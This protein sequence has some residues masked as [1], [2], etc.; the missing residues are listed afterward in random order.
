MLRESGNYVSG[1]QLCDTF[2]VSRT[3]VWKVINQLKEEGYQV[4]AVRNR[5]YRIADSPDVCTE[6]ELNSLMQNRTTWAGQ[7]IHYYQEID[8][9]NIRAKQM[10]EQGAPQGTLV[11]ADMQT[12]GRGRR[13]RGWVSPPGS[14]IYMSLLL[15]P[16][17]APDKAPM[18]TL[19]MAYSVAQALNHCLKND[20]PQNAPEVRIKWPNDIVLN[21]KKIVGILTEMST[22]I[23]YINHVVI[24]VGIN[25]NMDSFPEEIAASATSLRIETGK[26][27]KRAPFIV[28]I[29]RQFEDNYEQFVRCEDLTFLQKEYDCL[30]VNC[31]REVV[32]HEPQHTYH[33]VALGINE[34]GELIVRCD[35]G[36]VETVY[37]GEVSVRGIYGYV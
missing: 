17:F 36:T 31:G 2:G 28:E 8:S 15:K 20:F 32:I 18:L 12:A 9:T 16:T 34:K 24:G 5:G 7:Y 35:D 26:M 25:V 33:A 23:D 13:G 6:E 4:D 14:S 1:Q 22:E 21:G 3:A 11:V 37:A 10:G 30:L 27:M 29:M 19:V